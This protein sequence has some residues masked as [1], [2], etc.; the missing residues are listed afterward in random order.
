MIVKDHT[1]SHQPF[2][3]GFDASAPNKRPRPV[4]AGSYIVCSYDCRPSNIFSIVVFRLFLLTFLDSFDLIL[5]TALVHR[6]MI[7]MM[8]IL[9]ACKM[10]ECQMVVDRLSGLESG[11]NGIY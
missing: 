2:F 9:R 8:H 5:E 10:K 3:P 6:L 1:E 4:R 7:C 11:W